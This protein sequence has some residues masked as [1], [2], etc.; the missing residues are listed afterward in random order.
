MSSF[1]TQPPPPPTTTSTPRPPRPAR[2]P[3]L[4]KPEAPRRPWTTPKR[5]IWTGAF[6]A[7]TIVGA[8]YGAGLKTQQEYKTEKKKFIETPPEERIRTLEERRAALVTTKRP[9]EKKLG[10]LRLR[11]QEQEKKTRDNGHGGLSKP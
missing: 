5:L 10:E 11:V 2:R 9:L 8:I 1:R 3:S 6:A 7:V 4:P